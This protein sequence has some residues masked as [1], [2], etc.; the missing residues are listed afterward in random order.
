M[1]CSGESGRVELHA[2]HFARLE[3]DG[4]H[5]SLRHSAEHRQDA[6]D[7]AGDVGDIPTTLVH[8]Y[9]DGRVSCGDAY[10]RGNDA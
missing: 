2:F 3:E 5:Q 10:Q 7:G 6:V 8:T 9:R 4:R 1:V